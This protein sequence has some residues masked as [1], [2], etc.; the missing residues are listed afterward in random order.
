[1]IAFLLSPVG[2]VLAYAA[3]ILAAL[4]GI[5]V[6]GYSDGKSNVQAKWDRAVQ[7]T[8]EKGNTARQDAERDIAAEPDGSV[9]DDPYNRDRP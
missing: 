1:M 8:I 6:K 3:V 2:R 9:S 4:G 7:A 5:Y